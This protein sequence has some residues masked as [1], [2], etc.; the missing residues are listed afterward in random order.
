MLFAIPGFACA[1]GN[2]EGELRAG[3]QQA[4]Y[5]RSFSGARRSGND[6][7]FTRIQMEMRIRLRI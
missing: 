7:N 3:L 6:N 4:F 5:Q 2:R 1:G